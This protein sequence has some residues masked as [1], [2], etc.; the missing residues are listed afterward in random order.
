M[1]NVPSS[2]IT[3]FTFQSG[4]SGSGDGHGLVLTE[5]TKGTMFPLQPGVTA[6]DSR[7]RGRDIQLYPGM[8]VR[9]K[10]N[11]SWEAKVPLFASTCTQCLCLCYYGGYDFCSEISLPLVVKL[12]YWGALQHVDS[13]HKIFVVIQNQC[14]F[15]K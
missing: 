1:C 9:K 7:L 2:T 10:Q 13:M 6:P 5:G 4:S 12:H 15:N 8:T 3:V 11:S 14:I